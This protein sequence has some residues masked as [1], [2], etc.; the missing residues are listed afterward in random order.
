MPD[1]QEI[2]SRDGQAVWQTAYR[3]LGNRADAEEC[4][5]ETFLAAL[6]FSRRKRVQ[7]WPA[8]LRR[9]ATARA[10]DR[11]RRR[12][13]Q[14]ARQR[15]ADWDALPDHAPTPPQTAEDAELS[16]R[17][18]MALGRIPT[19][20]AQAFC[21][22]CLEGWTYQEVAE[23]LAVSVDSVGVLVHR[24]R[25]RL[26]Q[27]LGPSLEVAPAPGGDPASSAAPLCVRKEP[28]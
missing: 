9:L 26:R 18:R 7:S 25:T 1:W 11:L 16:E 5:Q 10:V 17:L 15:V 22:H 3:I 28:L 8:L 24:A 20:Q 6:E 4:F 2:L 19:R 23:Q 14:A 27:L 12:H 21:M 13:R